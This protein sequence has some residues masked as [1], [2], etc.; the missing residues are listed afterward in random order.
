MDKDG[1]FL[2]NQTTTSQ[3]SA[4]F[5]GVMDFL[6]IVRDR[7]VW[8]LVVALPVSLLFAYKQLNVNETYSAESTFRLKRKKYSTLLLL[9]EMIFSKPVLGRHVEYLNSLEFKNIVINSFSQEEKETLLKEYKQRAANIGD[10][11]PQ[12]SQLISYSVSMG[13]THTPLISVR[14]TS[15]HDGQGA[16]IIANKVQDEYLKFAKSTRQDSDNTVLIKLNE[17]LDRMLQEERAQEEK[18]DLFTSEQGIVSIENKRQSILDTMQDF[19]ARIRSAKIQKVT[20][21]TVMLQIRAVR[22][23]NQVNDFPI[24]HNMFR[25]DE[26]SAFG[27]VS[28]YR[29]SIAELK[30]D[31]EKLEERY[32][33]RHPKIISNLLLPKNTKF[34][35]ITKSNW[36][37]S[38]L[39]KKSKRAMKKSNITM[40]NSKRN[41]VHLN[42]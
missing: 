10:P 18:L 32:L 8:G 7:W 11:V 36:L 21:E 40:K 26:V 14:A 12:L 17:M 41:S 2:H 28:D 19:K 16:S 9:S 29:N 13:G 35:L 4:R 33:E 15:L 3:N 34:S 31:K 24:N 23:E 5:R 30:R 22:Q 25:I 38:H 27:N 37:N 1:D 20:F 39:P 6:L 42:L